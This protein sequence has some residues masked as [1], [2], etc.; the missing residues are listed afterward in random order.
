MEP[1]EINVLDYK[2]TL[3]EK[4][5]AVARASFEGDEVYSQLKEKIRHL[6]DIYHLMQEDEIKAFLMN[7]K[8]Y[9]YLAI[10]PDNILYK[11]LK[12]INIQGVLEDPELA[13]SF[14]QCS[15][16]TCFSDKSRYPVKDWMI[17]AIEKEVINSFLL[18][19]SK[20]L[21]DTASNAKADGSAPIEQ[22][23][24]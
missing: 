4:I 1:F 13:S 18:L 3:C 17:N 24:K 6:Y 14:N 7:G 5:S 16:E 10:H 2:R 19:E 8:N 12:K 9:L 23:T 20:A 11:S 22:Q 15:G 21:I